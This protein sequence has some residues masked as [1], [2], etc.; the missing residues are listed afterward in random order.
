MSDMSSLAEHTKDFYINFTKQMSFDTLLQTD[1][2]K[3][4]TANDILF[5]PIVFN[6]SWKP[7][8]GGF[9]PPSFITVPKEE[10]SPGSRFARP[11]AKL[12]SKF[13]VFPVKKAKKDCSPIYFDAEKHEMFN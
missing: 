9:I 6:L 5:R 11:W 10:C 13:G 12:G 2:P 7:S 1:I 3:N 4:W 8:D